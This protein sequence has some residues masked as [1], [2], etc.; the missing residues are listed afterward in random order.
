LHPTLGQNFDPDKSSYDV[1]TKLDFPDIN[2]PLRNL[3]QERKLDFCMQG[4]HS[5][6]CEA[7]KPDDSRYWV[8]F[9]APPSLGWDADKNSAYVDIPGMK[10][11]PQNNFLSNFGTINGSARIYADF[12]PSPDGRQVGLNVKSMDSNI[13][14]KNGSFSGLGEFLASTFSGIVNGQLKGMVEKPIAVDD[15]GVL[16]HKVEAGP[17]GLKTYR[18]TSSS[19]AISAASPQRRSASFST[20]VYPPA[21]CL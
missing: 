15:L 7:A 13:Q 12:V 3:T 18:S 16:V 21:R 4:E 11:I 14:M 8:M 19:T 20:R 1:A 2:E 5:V 9:T 6:T 10:V 17:D